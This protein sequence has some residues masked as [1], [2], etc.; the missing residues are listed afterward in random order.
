[1]MY[2]HCTPLKQLAN[3]VQ[4]VRDGAEAPRYSAPAR[5]PD[6]RLSRCYTLLIQISK[7]DGLVLKGSSD[8]VRKTRRSS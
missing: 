3:R 6:A 2:S 5:M 8:P 4:V 1:M 7:V